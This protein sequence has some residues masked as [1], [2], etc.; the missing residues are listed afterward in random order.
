MSRATSQAL[1][2][3]CTSFLTSTHFVNGGRE[4]K[5]GDNPSRGGSVGLAGLLD[6]SISVD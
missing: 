4:G 3:A 1:V 2:S 5:G 6:W